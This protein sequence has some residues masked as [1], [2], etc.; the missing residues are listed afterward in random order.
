LVIP[1]DIFWGPKI[2]IN[3]SYNRAADPRVLHQ[4]VRDKPELYVEQN[5]IQVHKHQEYLAK[6]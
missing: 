1:V 3:E 2:I 4:T 6:R 5:I